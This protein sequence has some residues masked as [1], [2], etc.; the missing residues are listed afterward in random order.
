[1][2]NQEPATAPADEK[3]QKPAPSV[4]ISTLTNIAGLS[5]AVTA[6]LYVFGYMYMATRIETFGLEYDYFDFSLPQ[7]LMNAL[8]F[9]IKGLRGTWYWNA[10]IIFCGATLLFVEMQLFKFFYKL[11]RKLT[12]VLKKAREQTGTEEPATDPSTKDKGG[13]KSEFVLWGKWTL[14]VTS[15]ALAFPLTIALFFQLVAYL[16]GTAGIDSA[17]RSLESF[18]QC[19]SADERKTTIYES[20]GKTLVA[21]G[22]IVASTPDM[23]AIY[24]D[25]K[26]RIYRTSDKIIEGPSLPKISFADCPQP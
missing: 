9:I 8:F 14:L 1:M 17:K 2:Q 20:D 6:L 16:S 4:W 22:F 12:A 7:V 26:A 10:A 21:R 13:F 18:N 25:G 23:T 11:L 15:F 3:P 5:G 24:A 19:P